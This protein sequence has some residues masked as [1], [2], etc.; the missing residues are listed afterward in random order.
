[1]VH[2]NSAEFVWYSGMT[3]TKRVVCVYC[4]EYDNGRTLCGRP[5]CLSREDMNTRAG[6]RAYRKRIG[7]QPHEDIPVREM[8]KAALPKFTSIRDIANYNPQAIVRLHFKNEAGHVGT[9]ECRAGHAANP[10]P[11]KIFWPDH[12][13]GETADTLGWPV[14][15]WYTGDVVRVDIIALH[16]RP[17]MYELSTGKRR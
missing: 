2:T 8:L 6:R 15:Y 1:M 9:Y 10:G 17:R 11:T 7:L 16:A 13:A 14:P 3:A 4:G 12:S 5:Q